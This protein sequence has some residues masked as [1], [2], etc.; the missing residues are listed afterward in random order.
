[1]A[2]RVRTVALS[3]LAVLV[4][5]VLGGI[6]AVGWQIVLGPTA[7]AVT[8][9]RFEA[10]EARLARGQYLT[11]AAACF[12]CHSEHDL[13]VPEYPVATGRRG[14]GWE[15]PIPELGKVVAPNITSD[16]VTGIGAW[17]DD[18]IARAIQEGISRDGSALFP[19]M[20][21]GNFRNLDEDDLASIVVFLRTVPAVSQVRQRSELI[22]P[23]SVL[24]NVMP[25]P[26]AAHAPVAR[27]TPET[28]G[29][30]LVRNVAG[31]QDCHSPAHNGDPLDGMDLGG[32]FKLSDPG[33]NMAPVFALNITSDPSGIAHYDEGLFVEV[34]QTGHLPGRMLS[35]IMPFGNFRNFTEGDLRDMFAYLKTVPPVKHRI[36]NT[37]PPTSC[38]LCE[39]THGL[40][41]R[42]VKTP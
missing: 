11:E 6:T 7:R 3:L 40:G 18:E 24:V 22:F 27:T 23:L 10:T 16:P 38:P 28:R 17:S 36:S 15:M 39:G 30:Y 33:R 12:H 21:Y 13:S 25:K 19:L 42:N 5:V 31:C 34:L 29:E 4:V 8:D 35:H 20:P 1:M 32:G 26:M 14:A 2:V 37:D 9:R 41:D